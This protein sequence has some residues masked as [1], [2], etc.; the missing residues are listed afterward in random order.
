MPDIVLRRHASMV[1]HFSGR[2]QP[3]RTHIQ[4]STHLR[5]Q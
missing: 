1:T 3:D 4:V 2:F 5:E